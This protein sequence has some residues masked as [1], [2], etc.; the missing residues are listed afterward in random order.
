MRVVRVWA[1]SKASDRV[2]CGCTRDGSLSCALRMIESWRAIEIWE[3]TEVRRR[4][5]LL[6]AVER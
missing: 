4:N 1:L 3:A 2:S 6:E 5:R